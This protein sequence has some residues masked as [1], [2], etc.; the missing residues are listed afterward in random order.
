MKDLSTLCSSLIFWVGSSVVEQ[1][2]LNLLAVGSN[3]TRPTIKFVSIAKKSAPRKGA[4]IA[5]PISPY[6]VYD[7]DCDDYKEYEDN[8]SSFCTFHFP[9]SVFTVL[10]LL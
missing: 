2:T 8:D 3:P 10:F 6:F 4:L 7:K 1:E 9:F 5:F